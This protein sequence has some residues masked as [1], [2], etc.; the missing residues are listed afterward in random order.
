MRYVSLRVLRMCHEWHSQRI[1]AMCK[2]SIT[3]RSKRAMKNMYVLIHCAANC[4]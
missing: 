2:P 3:V 4:K 1:V